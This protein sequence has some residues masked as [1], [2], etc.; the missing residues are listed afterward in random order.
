M[1]R[2]PRTAVTLLRALASLVLLALLLLALPIT[3]LYGTLALAGPGGLHLSASLSGLLSGPDQGQL[4]VWVLAAI[5][6]LAWAM[7]ALSVLVELGARLRGGAAR[8]L[9]ALGWSQR[10]AALLLGAVFALLPAAG[11]FAAPSVA[12]PPGITA[13]ASAPS[14]ATTAEAA[15]AHPSYTVRAARPAETLW[16]IAEQQ[17]GS[18]ARWNDIA[19]LNQGRVMDARGTVFHPDTALAP[20]WKLL[21]PASAGGAETVTV[22]RGDT[23]SG[24][25]AAHHVHGGWESVYTANR[26]V[27]GADP[28]VIQ[29]GERLRLPGAVAVPSPARTVAPAEPV[30]AEPVPSVPQQLLP[31]AL[32]PVP[33]PTPAHA[34]SGPR[35][36]A[37][38]PVLLPAA[39]GAGALLA[40]GLVAQLTRSR[41]LQQRRRPPRRRVSMP[42][43]E[44]QLYE[45]FLR[46][47][48]DP[49]GL[50]LLDRTL[51]TL[52][53][54]CLDTDAELPVLA[55]VAL[56]PGGSVDL[57]LVDPAPAIAPFVGSADGRLWRCH[58]PDAALLSAE[59]ARDVPAP[60]P[61]LVTLGRTVDGVHILADLETVRHLHLDGSPDEVA[62]VSRA[63]VA[64]LAA[65]PLAGRM[66]LI[67]LGSAA[68]LVGRLVHGTDGERLVTCAGPEQALADLERHRG[69]VEKTLTDCGTEHPRAARSQGVAVD[70]WAPALL[71][72][73]QMVTHSQLLALD[74]VLAGPEHR[75][76]AAVT[77]AVAGAPGWH[78]DARPGH[79]PVAAGLPFAVELQRLGE[80][81]F[82]AAIA[83][84]S[85]AQQPSDL[86]EPAWT[87]HR[88]DERE[89][90]PDPDGDPFVIPVL[91]S[92]SRATGGAPAASATSV[93][94]LAADLPGGG[95]GERGSA[96]P[97]KHGGSLLPVLGAGRRAAEAAG[98]RSG[99]AEAAFPPRILMLGPVRVIGA[100]G[101]TPA[102][103]AET[104]RLT[105]VA[106]LLITHPEPDPRLLDAV[107]DPVPY[108]TDRLMAARS[109]P[110]VRIAAMDRLRTW[111]GAGPDGTPWLSETA[112][113]LHHAVS[114]DWTDFQELYRLGMNARGPAEDAAL[115]RALDLVRGGPFLGAHQLYPWAEPF[116]QDMISAVID[117]SHE[118]AKRCFAAGD[119]PGCEAALHRGLAAV[120]EAEILHRGLIRLYSTAG[121][122]DH[123]AASIT[124]LAQVNDALGCLDYEPETLQLF[125]MISSRRSRH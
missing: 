20:G 26:K 83:V 11:A 58:A 65:S 62:A 93:P 24:I 18:G 87:D 33:L 86:P 39:I 106:A 100:A 91:A 123:V 27:I 118:L 71:C 117:A 63:L 23:L 36:E 101:P 70:A 16:T 75:C 56:R 95:G 34:A 96:G 46:A 104:S 49:A 103:A 30:P 21:L 8:R 99:S 108:A 89:P 76:V 38:D 119:L 41:V 97:G 13:P 50:D 125:S 64:E 14:A 44:E 53:M 9:P 52:G 68:A 111:L 72:T 12:P 67:T 51:R 61:A 35:A 28:D 116:R 55:A 79:H 2:R 77:P 37:S 31:D 105:A 88:P 5:G 7:F 107:L 98:F 54:A 122:R 43:V 81:E 45:T 114:C 15:V 29:P 124:R 19:A 84:L 1:G 94:L 32:T 6:W 80:E 113:R 40:A 48:A 47:M 57:H 121:Y 17:L 112:W 42:G 69:L 120:P 60:Y 22:H 109:A 10:A 92:H 110:R 73:D 4:V 115:R 85:A 3:L 25:A 90:E 59:R 66:K 82:A 78:L 74:R 102:D